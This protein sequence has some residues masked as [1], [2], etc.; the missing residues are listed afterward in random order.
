[1]IECADIVDVE[2]LE[3]Q[4]KILL[5]L[6]SVPHSVLSVP[7]ANLMARPPLVLYERLLVCNRSW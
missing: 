7:D 1:M 2:I 6:F 3:A 4:T 5:T